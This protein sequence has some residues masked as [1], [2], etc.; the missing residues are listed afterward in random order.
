MS[1]LQSTLREAGA[2][3]HGPGRGHLCSIPQRLLQQSPK[4]Q[5]VLELGLNKG[6]GNVY[7]DKGEVFTDFQLGEHHCP[8]LGRETGVLSF[9]V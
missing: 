6:G 4:R 1:Y 8:R 3:V 7:G 5:A 9:S 2:W